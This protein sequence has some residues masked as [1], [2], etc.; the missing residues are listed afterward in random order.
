MVDRYR[1][2]FEAWLRERVN[3]GAVCPFCGSNFLEVVPSLVL[4]EPPKPSDPNWRL[5][6]PP[7]K[8]P[9]ARCQDCGY[10]L[11]F[12]DPIL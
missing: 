8:L 7:E 12:K 11:L 2:A 10:I 3:D 9:R 4:H 1:D 6:R 5:A